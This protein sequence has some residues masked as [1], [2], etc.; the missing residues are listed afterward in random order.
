M[1]DDQGQQE[2]LGATTLQEWPSGLFW[3]QTGTCMPSASQRVTWAQRSRPSSSEAG[4]QLHTPAGAS[5]GS[6]KGPSQVSAC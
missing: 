4:G 6:L 3:S 1:P 5:Q 2:G